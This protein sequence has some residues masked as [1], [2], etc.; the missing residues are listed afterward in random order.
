M[1]NQDK[2]KELI[3]EY[4]TKGYWIARVCHAYLFLLLLLAFF[5]LILSIV[6]FISLGMS[7][8]LTPIINYLIIVNLYYLSMLNSIEYMHERL[9]S[10]SNIKDNRGPELAELTSIYF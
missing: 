6:D 10:L 4:G 9:K 1:N 7:A 5:G 8:I 2:A 3:K